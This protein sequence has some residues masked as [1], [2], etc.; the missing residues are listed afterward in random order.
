MTDLDDM[1]NLK[2]V[3]GEYLRLYATALSDFTDEILAKIK[4]ET[5]DTLES[6]VTKYA[7]KMYDISNADF[8]DNFNPYHG[9]EQ[10]GAS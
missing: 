7:S 2:S 3:K 1:L 5:T 4:S 6:I 9:E 8:E 10:D